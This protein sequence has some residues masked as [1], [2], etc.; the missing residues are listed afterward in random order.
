MNRFLRVGV[1]A[2]A[3]TLLVGPIA[4]NADT[5]S[6]PD[7]PDGGGP[8]YADITSVDVNHRMHRINATI[9][10]A[11]VNERRLAKTQVRIQ[12]KGDRKV[13]TVT[14]TR[15]RRGT[16]TSKVLTFKRPGGPTG[17]IL[18]C[19]KIRTGTGAKRLRISVP[20]ACI[21]GDHRDKRVRVKART[22]A[23]AGSAGGVQM[24]I[25][26]STPYTRYLARG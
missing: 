21:V 24:S 6:A 9:R 4:A 12:R 11:A 18:G 1:V 19:G 10:M 14:V 3:T 16:V 2:T 8:A 23:R 7:G 26:D 22:T 15:N 5:G 13:W 20:T 17:I 25:V